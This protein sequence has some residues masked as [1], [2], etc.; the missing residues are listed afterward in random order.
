MK[1][2]ER[3]PNPFEALQKVRG[4]VVLEAMAFALAVASSG[5]FSPVQDDAIEAI[6]P[7]PNGLEE[8]PLHYPGEACLTCHGG[9]GPGEPLLAVGGTVY[10]TP[11]SEVPVEGAI[12]RITD[13]VGT[14]VE[15]TSNCAGNFYLPVRE[16]ALFFPLRAEVECTLPSGTVRRSVMGTRINRDGSCASCHERGPAK[17]TGPAQVYC[18]DEMPEPAFVAPAN[19]AT[20]EGGDDD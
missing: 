16:K 9:Y 7:E 15:L 1:R 5:C 12:V 11:S 17:P 18:V 14:R 20:E 2:F 13:A 8:G 4:A 3:S 19:C 6:G 10:A